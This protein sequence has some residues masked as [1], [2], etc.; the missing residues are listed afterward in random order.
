MNQVSGSTARDAGSGQAVGR[1]Q[2]WAAVGSSGRQWPGSWLHRRQL[3][4][5][6]VVT[7]DSVS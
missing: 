2:Q 5:Q 7:L 4:T 1:A 3:S 6:A